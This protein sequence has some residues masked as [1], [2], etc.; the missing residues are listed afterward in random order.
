MTINPTIQG[1]ILIGL[2]LVF[3][4]WPV[5]AVATVVYFLAELF[6]EELI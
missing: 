2:M 4:F 1:V 3:G 5:L 6:N